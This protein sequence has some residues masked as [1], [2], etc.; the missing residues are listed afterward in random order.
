MKT[1]A[2]VL[3]A[4][5]LVTG[6]A[7]AQVT[8]HVPADFPTIQAA[9]NA[10]V[11]GDTVLVA[12]GTYFENINFGQK[13]IEVRSEA[14]M[15]MT[16]IDGSLSGSTV[17]ISGS[18]HTNTT[19]LEGFTV[20]GGAQTGGSCGERGT[21]LGVASASPTIAHCRFVANTTAPSGAAVVT[22]TSSANPVFVQCEFLGSPGIN[23][24]LLKS[25]CSSSPTV[26]E[27]RF[28]DLWS[29]PDEWPHSIM[30]HLGGHMTIDQCVI[31]FATDSIGEMFFVYWNTSLTVTNS[32][33]EFSGGQSVGLAWLH[34][35]AVTVNI[36][37]NSFNCVDPDQLFRFTGSGHTINLAKSNAF[38][39]D[40][41]GEPA[42]CLA[43][44]G[45]L[46]DDGIVNGADISIMLGF[47]GLNGKPVDADINGDGLA[48]L[49]SSWGKCP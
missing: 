47:W 32:V 22:T 42:P 46:N 35:P 34:T 5:N 33:M 1:V 2:T 21:A 16:T 18:V 39:F 29:G 24:C 49:L 23:R 13:R 12:P 38:T 7:L 40:C 19:R 20:R 10:A 28:E 4:L 48:M 14:G 30:Q 3:F 15:E 37:G 43:C 25:M 8:R 11:D 44:P 45:D 31:T 17:L 27:S 26:L 6:S 36:S 41:C 9:I